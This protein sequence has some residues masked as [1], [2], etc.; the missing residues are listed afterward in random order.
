M[1]IYTYTHIYTLSLLL[2]IQAAL[3]CNIDGF[4]AYNPSI[5][6]FIFFF[7]LNLML[8]R[9]SYLELCSKK[10]EEMSIQLSLRTRRRN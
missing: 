7:P 1:Y 9:I 2:S 8:H 10:E 5:V 3:S 4:A 6:V